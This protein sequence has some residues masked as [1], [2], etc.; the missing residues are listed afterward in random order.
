MIEFKEGDYVKLKDNLVIDNK[1]GDITLL[2]SMFALAQGINI[3]ES[4]TKPDYESNNVIYLEKNCFGY[5]IE[6]FEKI[7]KKTYLFDLLIRKQITEKEYQ[8]QLKTI[9]IN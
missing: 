7:D 5:S 9:K 3:I 2:A 4:I 6:M 1:Y 8:K